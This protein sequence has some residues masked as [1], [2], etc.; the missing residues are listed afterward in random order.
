MLRTRSVLLVAFGLLGL[1]QACGGSSD[2][3]PPIAQAPNS[4]PSFTL[5]YP[6][7]NALTD[8]AITSVVGSV[9]DAEGDDI[10]SV[11][12]TSPVETVNGSLDASG[13]W[14]VDNL[15][16][17][18]GPNAISVTL[19]DSAGSVQTQPLATLVS[20][21]VLTSTGDLLVT[22]D[23][24]TALVVDLFAPK[25][26]SLDVT[27]GL[28]TELPINVADDLLN[29]VDLLELPDGTILVGGAFEVVALNLQT[30]TTTEFVSLNPDLDLDPLPIAPPTTGPPIAVLAG[31]ALDPTTMQLFVAAADVDRIDVYD[32]NGE[33]PVLLRTFTSSNSLAIRQAMVFVPS[34]DALVLLDANTQEIVQID[35]ETGVRTTFLAD[36]RFRAGLAYD[37]QN[38]LIITVAQG[39]EIEF[40][41]PSTATVIN[42]INIADVDNTLT[43][44]QLGLNGTDPVLLTTG[45]ELFQLTTSTNALDLLF[46][47]RVGDGAPLF[48][49]SGVN[50]NLTENRLIASNIFGLSGIDLSTGDRSTLST[51]EFPPDFIDQPFIASLVS[52]PTV[53]TTNENRAFTVSNL[54]GGALFETDLINSASQ[55][56][57]STD[58]SATPNLSSVG[59]IALNADETTLFMTTGLFSPQFLMLDIAS[60]SLSP[61][62]DAFG[63][64]FLVGSR[65]LFFDAAE[66][67][68]VFTGF[69]TAES[70]AA[71]NG[72]SISAL[73]LDD[74]TIETLVE[75]S[76]DLM[77]GTATAFFDGQ[78]GLSSIASL[79]VVE[80]DASLLAVFEIATGTVSRTALIDELGPQLQG[81]NAL[82]AGLPGQ[83]YA[84]SS[85]GFIFQIDMQTGARVVISR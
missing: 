40:I 30:G 42:T 35:A 58:S 34:I 56:I 12:F 28:A 2:P 47:G 13:Q 41:D 43:I 84:T 63:Q 51:F 85:F 36:D 64:V 14:R 22:A 26:I 27:S 72:L 68:L 9:A 3:S 79:S 70:V 75:P 65:S 66:N 20:Q 77:L 38:D 45:S 71:E 50:T 24:Q 1:L 31:L 83:L 29:V 76:T 61:L 54:G 74:L 78:G 10:V 6:T 39:S 49:L 37:A 21:P 52:P 33:I 48:G 11:Q 7:I 18:P 82:I 25:L 4:A 80:G 69:L 55:L 44:D 17:E 46:S 81:I 60:G 62:I 19:E 8:A 32:V 16:L 5:I 23:G 53:L 59:S 67:R 15:S 73:N 57:V